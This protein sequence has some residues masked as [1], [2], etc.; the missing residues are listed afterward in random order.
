VREPGDRRLQFRPPRVVADPSLPAHLPF[1]CRLHRRLKCRT[2]P[3]W[4]NAA[5]WVHGCLP[6]SRATCGP[7]L[8]AT[9]VRRKRPLR[10]GLCADLGLGLCSH[11][12]TSASCPWDPTAQCSAMP[13]TLSGPMLLQPSVQPGSASHL[14]RVRP[15]AA[16][17]PA[18][19]NAQRV[20][21]VRHTARPSSVSTTPIAVR[22]L[23]R[24]GFG[25]EPLR[26]PLPVEARNRL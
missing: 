8:S 4:P 23:C 22:G 20:Q 15:V 13:R 12:C 2:L 3:G 6:T 10:T 5:A 24:Q 7:C 25:G 9:G 1:R 11:D 17:L 26:G 19:D 14:H 21:E 16:R 18:Q